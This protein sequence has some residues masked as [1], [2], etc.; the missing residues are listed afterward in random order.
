MSSTRNTKPTTAR[1]GITSEP[2]HQAPLHAH[3][4]STFHTPSAA[5]DL[6]LHAHYP[7]EPPTG[8]SYNG[9]VHYDAHNISTMDHWGDPWADD[10]VPDTTHAHTHTTSALAETPVKPAPATL[11]PGLRPEPTLLS[12]FEDE[13]GWGANA[14]STPTPSPRRERDAR[15]EPVGDLERDKRDEVGGGGVDG[16]GA[17]AAAP[18]HAGA[19]AVESASKLGLHSGHE[20]RVGQDRL[21]HTV[22]NEW[23]RIE[24]VV[25]SE[26]VVNGVSE[27][28]DSGTTIQADDAPA[29]GDG[30][31]PVEMLR[32]DDDSTRSSEAHSDGSQ[33][34]AVTESPRTSVEEEHAAVKSV[35]AMHDE[36]EG[37][38][39][40]GSGTRQHEYVEQDAD[41]FG[42]FEDE[43]GQDAAEAQLDMDTT[44]DRKEMVPRGSEQD[45]A[46]ESEVLT[47]KHIPTGPAGSF[48]LDPKLMAELFPPAKSSPQAEEAPDDPISST[49]TRKAWY[50]ITRKQTMREYNTGAVD[51]NYIRVTW[52]TSH[53]KS[54][55]VKTVARW[56]NEDR[57]AGRGPGARASF[58]WDSPH[59][60]TD[61]RSSYASL[62]RKKTST[63]SLSNP[64]RP[65]SQ[66]LPPLSTDVAAAFEWSSPAPATQNSA[67]SPAQRSTSTPI[68]AK[69]S[70]ITK[71]Q[72]QSGRAVSVD[73]SPSARA[74]ASHR[75]T[76]T[77]T[78]I[79]P[80]PPVMGSSIT[81]IEAPPRVSFDPWSSTTAS[82]PVAPV[83]APS[84]DHF[85][86][87][88]NLGA[89]DTGAPSKAP[90]TAPDDDDEDWGEMVESPAVSTVQTPISRSQTPIVDSLDPPPRTN[91]VS[92]PPTA[93]AP[94]RSS[95]LQPSL[96][97]AAPAHASP[98]VRLKGTVSPTSAIFGAKAL[99][100]TD[101]DERIGPHLLKKRSASRENTPEKPPA[102][103]VHLLSMDETLH[104]PADDI[105][106]KPVDPT[107][108]PPRNPSPPPP[109]E[110]WA[111]NADFSIFESAFP[112]AHPP[113]QSIRAPDPSDPWSIFNTPHPAQPEPEPFIRPAPRPVTPP[114]KQPLNSATSSAQRRKAEEDEV[115]KGIVGGLPDLGYMLR[116]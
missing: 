82:S 68:T 32:E 89:L 42:D 62:H 20:E 58:F 52:K 76:S 107:P 25:E 67:D 8:C 34:E 12:G 113:P 6:D 109:D 116:R 66:A 49:S 64:S 102:L 39:E 31:I 27:T 47:A 26:G 16:F 61:K 38:E 23:S 112:P 105:P 36:V 71:L 60:P 3:P 87:W 15:G 88:A 78:E 93:A 99:V 92:T 96:P 91:T 98:I 40:E 115:V 28:S 50:R 48:V 114:A 4:N 73:L 103:P 69:H 90:I 83:S 72:R 100:L 75:R 1:L 35:V 5:L 17:W 10:A 63:G 81:P 13:A 41:D 44:S 24:E 85:D 11:S 21:D 84:T 54:E 55:V 19:D 95:P 70:A 106:T 104:A 18:V 57:L 56:A 111:S 9:A 43:V 77:A 22:G 59:S 14:W 101:S 7:C 86:P 80:G 46:G 94:V 97:P 53:I 108:S 37:S 51:D 45:V 33:N 29:Q 79:I 110:T 74:I 30:D 65:V 2:P